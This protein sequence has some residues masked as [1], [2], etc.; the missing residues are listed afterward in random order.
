MLVDTLDILDNLSSN[1]SSDCMMLDILCILLLVNRVLIAL[2]PVTLLTVS[3]MVLKN[4]YSSAV[5]VSLTI[6]RK[7]VLVKVSFSFF[8]SSHSMSYGY[9]RYIDC[10]MGATWSRLALS[11]RNVNRFR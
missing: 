4:M 11:N 10:S 2:Y 6:L 1:G 3:S 7:S 5:R 8:N 9:S